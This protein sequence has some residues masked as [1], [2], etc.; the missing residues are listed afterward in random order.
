[1]EAGP[2]PISAGPGEA[3]VMWLRVAAGDSGLVVEYRRP[4]VA[5]EEVLIE[6]AV[7]PLLPGVRGL[8]LRYLIRLGD[9]ARWFDS[10]SSQVRP[11]AAIE[12]RLLSEDEG[13][14]Y[15]EW[16]PLLIALPAQR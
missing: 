13:G 3:I 6:P 8:N 11:P 1:V 16:P 4:G 5:G 12:L 10:W 2:L 14:V 9:E 15:T 7:L